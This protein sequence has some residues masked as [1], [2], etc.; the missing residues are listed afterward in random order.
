M[1]KSSSD[2]E[3]K[4]LGRGRTQTKIQARAFDE[5]AKRLFDLPESARDKFPGSSAL[6]RALLINRTNMAKSA[7]RRHLRH[8]AGLLRDEGFT[9]DDLESYI[10]GGRL[11]V[12]SDTGPDLEALRETLCDPAT[13]DDALASAVRLL[14]V[15]DTNAVKRYAHAV[16]ESGDRRAFSALFKVLRQAADALAEEQN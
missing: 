7:L 5:I 12:I 13:F 6:A 8:I 11:A 14:P 1:S 3:H 4:D 15:L 9:A 16:H 10:H 2:D